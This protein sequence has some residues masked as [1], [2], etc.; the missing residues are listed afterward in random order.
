MKIETKFDI[1]DYVFVVYGAFPNYNVYDGKIS[2]CKIFFDDDD[3]VVFYFVD[4]FN[5]KCGYYREF[6]VFG[7]RQ[8]A[9]KYVE[10]LKC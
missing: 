10:E 7:S 6:G 4:T 1:G 3:V 2:C 8:D 9:E 5:N